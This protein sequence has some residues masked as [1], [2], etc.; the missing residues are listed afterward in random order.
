LNVDALRR[1]VTLREN[2]GENSVF[3]VVALVEADRFELVEVAVE[4]ERGDGIANAVVLG[5]VRIRCKTK[6]GQVDASLQNP[7]QRCQS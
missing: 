7:V 4:R 5:Y 1:S 3:D 2:G 6:G